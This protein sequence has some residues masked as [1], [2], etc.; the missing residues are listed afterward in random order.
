MKPQALKR[1]KIF[2]FPKSIPLFYLLMIFL[3]FPLEFNL[4]PSGHT[5]GAVRT[6]KADLFARDRPSL[7]VASSGVV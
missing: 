1:H 7:S 2:D 3:H 4:Y 5:W 6:V